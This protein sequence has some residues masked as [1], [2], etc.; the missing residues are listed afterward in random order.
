MDTDVSA[1]ISYE[2]FCTLLQTEP[3]PLLQNM[4][5]LFDRDR[6]GT[7]DA[8]E[9]IVGLSA[10]STSSPEEKLRFAFMMF[11]DNQNGTLDRVEV[12]KIVSSS[13]PDLLPDQIQQRVNELYA[14]VKLPP[15]APVAF[16]HFKEIARKKPDLLLP[17]F[18]TVA[19]PLDSMLAR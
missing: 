3:S 10:Y 11:D 17:F 4:F 1:T 2:E 7:I 13:T 12:G 8:R 19:Q 14:L 5:L 15:L 6:N 9:L 18:Q 16:D